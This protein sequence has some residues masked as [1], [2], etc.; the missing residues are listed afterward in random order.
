MTDTDEP[1]YRTYHQPQPDEVTVRAS[2]DDDDGVFVVRMP[3]ASSGEVR[4]DGDDPLSTRELEGMATQVNERSPGVFLDHGSNHAIAGSRYSAVGKVGEWRDGDLVTNQR[5]E[6]G[7]ETALLVAEARL[8]D[9]ETLPTATGPVREA[10]AAIK[11]QVERDITIAASIGW[12]DD[13]ASPGGVDLMEASLV[14]I[15]ADPRTTSQDAAVEL[16]RTVEAA[17]ED[18]DPEALVEQFRAVVMGPDTH[19]MTE[20]TDESGGDTPDPDTEQEASD[21]DDDFREW[22]REQTET[23]TEILRTLADAIRESDDDED[24]EED[25]DEDDEDDDDEEQSADE[26]DEEQSADDDADGDTDADDADRDADPDDTQTIEIDGET[27]HAEDAVRA[28][29]AQLDT[30]E[31][32]AAEDESDDD[33]RDADTD[34]E[35]PPLVSKYGLTREV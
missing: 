34:D 7:E 31:P 4:N 14:G 2:D 35:R 13:D 10:L 28:L 33:D 32:D 3:I 9:P 12:R 18:A 5:E 20:E 27:V 16:A 17:R 22:M 19:D 29:R 26:P 11:S 8:M 24:D 21:D 30:A 6:D 1:Q 25:D 15:P 23:Q